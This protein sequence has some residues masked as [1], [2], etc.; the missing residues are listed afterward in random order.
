MQMTNDVYE[1]ELQELDL[2]NIQD[3]LIAQPQEVVSTEEIYTSE[4]NYWH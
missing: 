2:G 4:T 3:W 1:L